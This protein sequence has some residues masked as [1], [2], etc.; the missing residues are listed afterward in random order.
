MGLIAFCKRY[1]IPL[2]RG[3]EVGPDAGWKIPGVERGTAPCATETTEPIQKQ[4][5]TCYH[6]TVFIDYENGVERCDSNGGCGHIFKT[7]TPVK[8]VCPETDGV[9]KDACMAVTVK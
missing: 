3:P 9:C 8:H 5:E 4:V 1:Q 7:F 2:M 6:R